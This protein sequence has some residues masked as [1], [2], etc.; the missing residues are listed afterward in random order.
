MSSDARLTEQEDIAAME[1]DVRRLSKA[2][3]RKRRRAT[4]KY[5]NLHASRER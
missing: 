5:R 2:E 3:R 4:P 1:Q